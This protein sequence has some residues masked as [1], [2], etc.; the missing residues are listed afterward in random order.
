MGKYFIKAASLLILLSFIITLLPEKADAASFTSKVNA[1]VLNVRSKATTKSS[2]IGKIKKGKVVTVQSEQN[3]W[4]KITYDKKTG[5]VMSKYLTYSNWTG[6][7]KVNNLSIKKTASSSAK[8]LATIKI[9]TAV[10]VK[11]R[12]GSWVNVYYSSKKVTGWVSISSLTKSNPA[13]GTA[14]LGTYYV[15]ATSL[16]VR[17][18]ASTKAKVIT[19]V[20]KDAALTLQQK[21]GSWGKAKTSNGKVGWVSLSYLSTKK[22]V[23]NLGTYYVTASS[24]SVR[25]KASTKSKIITT[26]KKNAAVTLQQKSGSWGKVETSNGKI[27]WVSLTYIS[28]KKTVANLGTYYVTATSLNVREKANTKAK[29]ITTV[30]KNATVTL[31]QK[32]GT[33]GEV[34]TSN[35]KVGWVSLS[36][37][38]TKKPAANLGTYYVTASNLNV[39]QKADTSSKVITTVKKNAALTLQQKSGTWGKVK[40]SNGEI[41]WVAMKHISTK[42]PVNTKTPQPVSNKTEYLVTNTNTSLY[43]NADSKSTVLASVAKNSSVMKLNTNGSFTQVKLASGQIGWI[44]SKTLIVSKSV[45]GKVIVIDPGHGGSDTGAIGVKLKTKEKTINLSTANYLATILENAGATVI[46]TR[47]NDTFISLANRAAISNSKKADAFVSIHYNATPAASASGIETFYYQNSSLASAI[48]GELI[49]ATGLKDR[50]VK[51]GNFQVIKS[52]KQPA[53]LL[54]LGFLTNAAEEKTISQSSYHKKAAQGILNG[55]NVYF[56]NK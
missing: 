26:V 40:T 23:A 15:T 25:E 33:W 44:T 29:V 2:V 37:L 20:K 36:Y 41:G 47:S 4:S 32:S 48:H 18:T 49:K 55:L 13:N 6:Y 34:K 50:K 56:K 35:G 46:M 8:S 42:K 52:N 38:S 5:W 17:A 28:T 30:K 16:N 39:R 43:K 53:T 54:E 1:D 27:G 19:T 22:P 24:L 11:G 9:G 51:Q 12:M 7:A 3:N 31:Q 10:S 45:Q 21:I 14:N